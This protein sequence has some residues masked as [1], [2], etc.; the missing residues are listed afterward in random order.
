MQQI[1]RRAAMRKCDFNKVA[2]HLLSSNFCWSWNHAWIKIACSAKVLIGKIIVV[3]QSLIPQD[4]KGWLNRAQVKVK[5]MAKEK[6]VH[7][8]I[9]NERELVKIVKFFWGRQDSN[10]PLK[11]LL[12]LHFEKFC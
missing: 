9:T 4:L 7:G 6:I 2:L 5:V 11:I 12:A 8:S 1:Y 10:F 3:Q